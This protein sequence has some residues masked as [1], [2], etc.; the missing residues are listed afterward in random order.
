MTKLDPGLL[1]E[2]VDA[3]AKHGSKQ[4][5]AN[6]L[7]LGV[8]TL[9]HRLELAKAQ[10]IVATLN[11][12]EQEKIRL[13]DQIRDLEAELKTVRRDN[14]SV[15]MVKKEI[16]KIAETD[17]KPPRWIEKKKSSKGLAGIPSVLWS[18]W[19]WGE[20]VSAAQLGGVN[21]YDLK[22]AH[23]RLK[24]LVEGTIDLC[25]NHMTGAEYPGIIVNLGGDMVSGNIHDELRKTNEQPIL[26]VVVDIFE[27]LIWALNTLA[28]KFGR[29]FVPCVVGN[30]GRLTV[31]P[32]FKNPAFENYDWLIYTLLE[33]HFENED[34]IKFLIPEGS[35]AYY[36]VC[37]HRYLLTH[38]DKLGVR[39]GDGI[40]GA[41]GP[42]IRGSK[43]TGETQQAIG[44]P[45]DTI[46]MGHWHQYIPLQRVIVNGS[47]K[48]YDEYVKDR[49][50][51]PPEPAQQAL[52]FTHPTH[53]ITCQWPV[54]CDESKPKGKGEWVQWAA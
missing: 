54:F 16:F 34:R 47:L 7:G 50:R 33:K 8:T 5:A 1:Q 38:G 39:G 35:D 9:K 53:G 2:M 41:I 43:K 15:E 18:D 19:H 45:F 28:D 44:Q 14:I 21:E 17:P 10:G 51:A 49:L 11:P 25:L 40:I 3:V 42:I 31:R 37:G 20:V 22:I 6:H 46:L 4:A 30:H 36:T 27:K 13:Q 29:V 26:P 24:R 12:D 52:F 23:D 48:G 32:E